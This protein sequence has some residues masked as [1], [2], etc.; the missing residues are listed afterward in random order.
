MFREGWQW[1]SEQTIK[2][3]WRSRTDSPDGA[4]DIATLVRR[5][6]AEVCTVPVFLVCFGLVNQ[7]PVGRSSSTGWSYDV[8]VNRSNTTEIWLSMYRT[9]HRKITHRP[10]P[11]LF[12]RRTPEG[13][14]SIAPTGFYSARN[15]RIASAVLATAIPSVCPSVCPSVRH[16]PVLCQNDGP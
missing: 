7:S 6:L 14:G 15:A 8:T 12:R 1:A 5:A 9:P 4:T 11:F 3:R 2:F 13:R 10:Y 16:T